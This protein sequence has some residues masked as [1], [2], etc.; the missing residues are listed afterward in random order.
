MRTICAI[1]LFVV[2]SFV[3]GCGGS[4]EPS[5]T[6]S[7]VISPISLIVKTTADGADIATADGVLL[8][9]QELREIATSSESTHSPIKFT[10]EQTVQAG[11]VTPEFWVGKYYCSMHWDKHYVGSCIRRNCWHLN[12]LIND[13]STGRQVFNSH[14]CGWWQNGPQFGIYNSANGVCVTSRGGFTAVK[15]AIQSAILRSVPWMP[16]ALAAGIAYVA[17]GISVPALAL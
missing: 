14:L 6:T 10:I 16:Y 1:L 11:E 17:A 15:N 2:M 7:P 5:P 8:S 9:A 13:S 3:A 4:D 12:L